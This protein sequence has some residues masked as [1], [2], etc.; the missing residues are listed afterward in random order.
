MGHTM[1]I[2]PPAHVK[3]YL[4]GQK[5]DA[6]DAKTI[7]EDI[8]R[9]AMRFV[10][11]KTPPLQTLQAEHR[12]RAGVV[13]SCTA[14]CNE[15]RSFLGEFGVV[16]PVGINQLRKELPEILS[17]QELWDDRFMRLLCELAEELR[18]LDERV[19]WAVLSREE[20]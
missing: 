17:Q 15:I 19:A 7:C 9:P 6:N 12:V 18:M 1:R 2:I 10:A 8:S 13:K 20:D 3:P 5:N 11:V 14:L 4:K 16:L